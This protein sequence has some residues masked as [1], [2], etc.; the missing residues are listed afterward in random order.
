MTKNKVKIL[1]WAGVAVVGLTVVYL[2]LLAMANHA[3]QSNYVALKEDGRPL[4]RSEVI[5]IK[6]DDA[7]NAALVYESVTLR[8]RAEPAG[9]NNLWRALGTA[10]EGVLA[11]TPNAAAIDE[12]RRLRDLP[13]VMNALAEVETGSRRSGYW[14]DLDYSRGASLELPHIH[15]LIALSRIICADTRLK[16]AA[17][18]P[19]AAWQSALTALRVA[20]A[21]K[22][23]PILICQL[24]SWSQYEMARK[25]I[26]TLPYSV[27]G[28]QEAEVILKASEEVAHVV[29]AFD[30][31]RANFGE[32]IFQ[33]LSAGSL[34]QHLGMIKSITNDGRAGGVGVGEILYAFLR[35]L[36]V[37]DRA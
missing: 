11:E 26:Q 27:E 30:C 17:G 9:T 3:L 6:A 28:H 15:E 4:T 7:D 13:S 12:F 18:K 8:L 37:W 33:D 22:D 10:S 29:G 36:Q 5:P 14:N 34:L 31:E 32:T 35:P 25:T 1:K 2:V 16:A 20:G 24:V 19:D 23:E 21:L